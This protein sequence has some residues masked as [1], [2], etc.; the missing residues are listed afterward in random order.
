MVHVSIMEKHISESGLCAIHLLKPT[1]HART[2]ISLTC[3][4][5]RSSSSLA[6][7]KQADESNNKVIINFI[8]SPWKQMVWIYSLKKNNSP[9][10]WE[11]WCFLQIFK[12]CCKDNPVQQVPYGGECL[13]NNPFH[14][15]LWWLV[16]GTSC[17]QCQKIRSRKRVSFLV[18]F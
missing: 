4:Q 11:A 10:I 13:I 2:L 7:E 3:S 15:V 9:A 6:Y 1:W 16:Q 8:F 17:E 14:L 5:E 12:I 18:L